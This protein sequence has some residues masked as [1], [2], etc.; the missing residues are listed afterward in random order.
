V[1]VCVLV[2]YRSSMD[3][4]AVVVK[5]QHHNTKATIKKLCERDEGRRIH[6][7]VEE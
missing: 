7:C 5:S 2:N 3:V 4:V 6:L 1:C